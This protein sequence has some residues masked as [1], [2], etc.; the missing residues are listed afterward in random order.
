MQF[1]S[2]RINHVH[3]NQKMELE[4]TIT[5]PFNLWFSFNFQTL[6]RR[7][8]FQHLARKQHLHQ[9]CYKKNLLSVNFGLHYDTVRLYPW[10]VSFAA[11]FSKK[12]C[13]LPVASLHRAI[14]QLNSGPKRLV[15]VGPVF[16]LGTVSLRSHGQF[17]EGMLYF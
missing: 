1:Y 17:P 8:A 4:I 2:T 16:L 11:T 12:L 13:F 3:F 6:Q 10:S 14:F 15:T 5:L 7:R 9:L